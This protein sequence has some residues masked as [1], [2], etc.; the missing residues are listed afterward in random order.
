MRNIDRL[1]YMDSLRATAMFL[2]LVLHAGVVFAQWTIDPMRSHDEP[3]MFLHYAMELIHVFRMELFFLVAGFFSVLLVRKRGLNYYVK[4]RVT[5]IL[6]PFIICI[7]LLQP[8]L[9]AGYYLDIIGSNESLVAQYITYLKTPGYIFREPVLIG[10]WLWH[11]W[12]MHLLI[13]FIACFAISSLI[14]DKLKIRLNLSSFMMNA[15]GGRLGIFLLTF[16]TYSILVFSP[17]WADVPRVGTSIDVLLYYGLFFVFGA[18][19]FSHQ[20]SLDQIQ[21]NAKYHIIPFLLALLILVPLIDELRLTTQ[22]EILLQN[23]ALFETVEARS[24]LLGNFPF[25][26]NPFNFSSL[27]A[28]SEWHLMC[29]LRAYTTWCGILFFICL[30]KKYQNKQTALGRYFAD[31]S[32]FI[33]LLHFPIQLPISYYLR[34]RIESAL[35]CFSIC[36][37]GSVVIC[38]LLYHFACRGTVIGTLLSG[39]RYSLNLGDEFNEIKN[40][41][42]RKAVCGSLVGIVVLFV[43]IDRAESKDEQKLLYYS[44]HTEPGNI[45]N[46]ITLNSDKDLSEITRWDGRNSL[47]LASSNMTKPRPDEAIAKSI[48]LLLDNGFNPNSIDNFG[49]TPLHYAVKNDNKTA[50]RLLLK[51]GANPNALETSYG[52]SPLHYAAT[53]GVEELIRPLVASGGKLELPRKNGDNSLDIFKKFHSKP[54]PAN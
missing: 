32:Y 6:L 4:N 52:N 10:S 30:F 8:L 35:L 5:R 25:F 40:F 36:L 7:T 11:F 38:L 49:L 22:P 19:F 43:I 3:S 2:G 54:F 21:A 18:L 31:S 27:N 42:R 13:Y 15:V 45:E 37:I 47:H 51:A 14:I 46:Y 48:Q 53:L 9:A 12:F 26:Q 1:H 28:P 33:Y 23:W 16:M 44:Q 50:I 24:G 17:P 20:R 29:L 34:D 41:M 39:R